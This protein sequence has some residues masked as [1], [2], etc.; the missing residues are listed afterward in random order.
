MMKVR[1]R[2]YAALRV[3]MIGGVLL[4]AGGAELNTDVMRYPTY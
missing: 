1:A 2:S 3:V 4:P